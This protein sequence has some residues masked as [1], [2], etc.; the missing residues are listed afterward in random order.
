VL[1]DVMQKTLNRKGVEIS[2]SNQY[3]DGLTF[4]FP[5]NE[6]INGL[7]GKTV[8]NNTTYS[9]VGEPFTIS[10]NGGFLDTILSPGDYAWSA[11]ISGT[12][13]AQGSF[14]IQKG[15]QVLLKFGK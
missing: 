8:N 12:G 5:G 3:A 14:S 9:I 15:Q 11:Q 10:G 2:V 13:Q 1:L 4:S 6:T 7:V